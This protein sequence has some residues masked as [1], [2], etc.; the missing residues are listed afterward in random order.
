[1]DGRHVTRAEPERTLIL[2]TRGRDAVVARGILRDAHLDADICADIHQLVAEIVGGA[3][4]A[5]ITEE[6]FRGV[7]T[8]ALVNWVASQ[9]VWSDFPF[10]VLTEH[11]GGLERNPTAARLTETLGNVNLLERPFHPTTLVSVVQT[12]L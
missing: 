5:I 11:G 12:N 6:A 10:I 2:A 7:D 4:L 9:P 1:L 8:R 3:E